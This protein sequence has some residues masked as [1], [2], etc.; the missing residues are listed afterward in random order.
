MI[1]RQPCNAWRRRLSYVALTA[2]LASSTVIAQTS[3]PAHAGS[4]HGPMQG[5]PFNASMQPHCPPDAIKNHEQGL[6]ILKVLVRTDGTA[7]QVTIDSDSTKASPELAK[8]ASDAAIKWHFSPRMENGKTV[9]A[10]TKVPVLF[11]LTQ[12]PPHPPGPPPHGLSPHDPSPDGPM[13][14]PPPGADM[15]PPPGDGGPSQPSSSSF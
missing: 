9:E 12:L 7:R 1:S 2:L 14:P 6:V 5:I 3:D 13:P 11:S 4:T 8:V 15:P 10:W